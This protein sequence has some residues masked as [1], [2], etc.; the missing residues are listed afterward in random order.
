[1][2]AGLLHAVN[3]RSNRG[4]PALRLDGHPASE[5]APIGLAP[6]SRNTPADQQTLPTQEQ[7]VKSLT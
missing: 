3:D 5:D 1:M 7:P 6:D 2:M 4:K